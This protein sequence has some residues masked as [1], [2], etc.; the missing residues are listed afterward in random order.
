MLKKVI[1]GENSLDSQ[2]WQEFET[3]NVIEFIMS[4]WSKFP[5]NTRI[6]HNVVTQESDIT[7]TNEEQILALNELEGTIYIVTY[8]SFFFIGLFTAFNGLFGILLLGLISYLLRPKP[9]VPKNTQENSPNNGLSNRIN[10]ARPLQRIPDIFGKVRSTPDLIAKPFMVFENHREVEYAYFCVGRGSY[11]IEDVKDDV[12]PIE[13]IAGTSVMVYGPGTSPHTLAG[14]ELTIGT[15]FTER[16]WNASKSNSVNGQI[17]R[18]PNASEIEGEN[19]LAF[20]WPDQIVNTGELNFEEYFAVDDDLTIKDSTY[21]KNGITVNLDGTYKVLAVTGQSISLVNPALVNPKWADLTNFPNSQTEFYSPTIYST[22][23]KWVGPFTV[24]DPYAIYCNFIAVNG[25]YKD[26]GKKQTQFDV[27]IEV[28][29]TPVDANG[30]VIGPMQDGEVTVIGSSALRNSRAATLKYTVAP[31]ANTK[32]TYWEVRA[33]RLTPMDKKFEGRIIDEIQWRD[34]YIM[35]YV[36][37]A[38]FGNVTTIYAKTYATSGALSIKERKLNCHATR[39]IPALVTG[40]NDQLTTELYPTSDARLI[41]IAAC[42]DPYIGRRT[43]SQIDF[44][45]ID[46]QVDRIVDYFGSDQILRFNHTFDDANLSFEETVSSIA[47]AIF[48]KAYRFGSKIRLK[49]ESRSTVNRMLFNH[50]NKI[51]RSEQRTIQ[52]GTFEDNDGVDFEYID[53]E[54]GATLNFL[55]PEDGSA[56]NPKKVQS[57]GIQSEFQAHFHAWRTYQKILYQNVGVE[58]EA[59]AEASLL[60]INDRILVADNTRPDTVDGQIM[61][62][63]GLNIGLSQPFVPVAGKSYTMAIQHFDQTVELLP[64]VSVPNEYEVVLSKPPKLPLVMELERYAQTTYI[65]SA[66]DSP[67]EKAFLVQEKE[68]KDN[69][70]IKVNAI[71]YDDRYYSHDTDYINGLIDGELESIFTADFEFHN[72]PQGGFLLVPNP[73]GFTTSAIDGVEIQNNVAGIGPAAQGDKH[74]E[75]DG[76]KVMWRDFTTTVNRRYRLQLNYSGRPGLGEVDN[77][78]ALYWNGLYVQ[79]FT[80]D[81]RQKT[82]TD[83]QY[84]EINLTKATGVWTRL[85]FRALNPNPNFGQGGLLDN[86]RLYAV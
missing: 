11:L 44:D 19:D 45:N 47:E 69:F 3:E 23:E 6:Y 42:L 68:P 9:P 37:Q 26:N 36:T 53:Q 29:F 21:T 14:P 13:D 22:A 18:A 5:D 76:Q 54:D 79:T 72:V 33:R 27:D 16:V 58:F 31:N 64:I 65:I 71:N 40:T 8:P 66:N 55:I 32:G 50:R 48:C 73:G 39:K 43:A 60:V 83:W 7:P 74:C 52:F 80:T 81:S 70:T 49:F 38:D 85:E 78:I 28:Q 75:L 25:L 15:P 2:T 67:R 51:P 12:T 30:N 82:E 4:R 84:F 1:I 86:I 63:N 59:T 17:L 62:Q 46:R 77:A 35:E 57:V 56:V 24:E 41:L 10:E 61:S 34:L 20:V